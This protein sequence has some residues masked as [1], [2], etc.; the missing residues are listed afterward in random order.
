MSNSQANRTNTHTLS[1]P[2]RKKPANCPCTPLFLSKHNKTLQQQT[3]KKIPP[4]CKTHHEPNMTWPWHLIS[5]AT[6]QH[7]TLQQQLA[8]HKNGLAKANQ[9]EGFSF[10]KTGNTGGSSNSKG[11]S[12]DCWPRGTEIKIIPI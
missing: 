10:F 4:A 11:A 6:N 9:K 1:H 7:L 2:S 3:K 12:Q 5:S 8:S